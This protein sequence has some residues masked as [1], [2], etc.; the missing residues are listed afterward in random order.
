MFTFLFVSY[1][2]VDY[3]KGEKIIAALRNPLLG[4]HFISP[5]NQCLNF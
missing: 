4:C 1:E 5:P 2:V 3:H